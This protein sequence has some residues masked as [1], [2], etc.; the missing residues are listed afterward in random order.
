MITGF[1]VKSNVNDSWGRLR[2]PLVSLIWNHDANYDMVVEEIGNERDLLG[3]LL[4][5]NEV[6]FYAIMHSMVM[7]RLDFLGYKY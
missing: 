3:N 6:H 2:S 1:A 5:S 4:E 7:K